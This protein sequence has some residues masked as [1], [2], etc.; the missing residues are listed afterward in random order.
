MPVTLI[1]RAPKLTTAASLPA[2]PPAITERQRMAIANHLAQQAASEIAVQPPGV[3][4]AVRASM[5][6]RLKARGT[7]IAKAYA[8]HTAAS[9]GLSHDAHAA[10]AWRVAII[11]AAA[12]V[13]PPEP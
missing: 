1:R 9:A 7:T 5:R 11:T 4:V 2:R 8:A 12:L 13:R 6:A 3:R 10:S